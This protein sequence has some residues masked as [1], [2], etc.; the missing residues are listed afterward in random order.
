MNASSHLTSKIRQLCAIKENHS[1]A[2]LK[3]NL[4]K[5]NSFN[6]TVVLKTDVISV[7]PSQQ[8][9]IPPQQFG[10]DLNLQKSLL[11]QAKESS[12]EKFGYSVIGY[13]QPLMEPQME[14]KLP[15]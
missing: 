6:T 15:Y 5:T 10:L 12:Q 14:T 1:P 8:Q 7:I 2:P 4:V 13:H 9:L 3:M 11:V